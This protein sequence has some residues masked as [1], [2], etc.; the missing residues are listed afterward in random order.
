MNDVPKIIL[1]ACCGGR[2]F[3]WQKDHPNVLYVDKRRSPKGFMRT[4]QH[5]EVE[6]DEIVDFRHMPFPDF[7]F[8]MVV[9]DPPH[10]V[11][12][13]TEEKEYGGII[14]QRYGRL[15]NDTW[16]DDLRQGFKECWRVL[17]WYG[18]L[19]FKWAESDKKLTE[20]HHLFPATPMFGSRAGNNGKT[21]W[22]V[23]MK[24]PDEDTT[25]PKLKAMEAMPP[26]EAELQMETV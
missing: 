20:L 25:G 11:R 12:P 9:F 26:I 19:V 17:E 22:L 10:T 2:M 24:T 18:F 8:K 13:F 15:H 5:F 16:E 1:D 14:A 3:W 4:R 21:V 7:S 23:F 6:P